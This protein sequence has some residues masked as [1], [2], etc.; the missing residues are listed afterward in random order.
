MKIW[1][2]WERKKDDLR[3]ELESHLRIAVEERMARGESYEEAKAAAT[4]EMG[5]ARSAR[6]RMCAMRC[7][8]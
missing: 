6:C 5:K 4:R 2:G 1:P 3:E 8:N 7:G